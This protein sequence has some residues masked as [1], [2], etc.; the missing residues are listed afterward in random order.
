MFL[1]LDGF[2]SGPNGELD[3]MPGNQKPDQEVDAYIYDMMDEMDTMLLGANTFE[4]F[5]DYWPTASTREEIIADKLNA[6]P[7]VVFSKAPE[8]SWG[9]WDNARP[10]KGTLA[11]EIDRLRHQSGKDMVMFGGAALA[12]SSMELGLIDE[13]KLVVSPIILGSGKPLFRRMKDRVDL[14]LADTRTFKSGAVL[15]SYVPREPR[16]ASGPGSAAR[17][18]GP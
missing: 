11:E 15:L 8:V 5:E 18:M 12:Q 7:K 10:A 3:W 17:G 1:T 13:F 14:K 4:V 9:K 16:P 6:M 2:I